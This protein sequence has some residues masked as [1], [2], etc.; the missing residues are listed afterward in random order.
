MV[1]EMKCG[2]GIKGNK[3]IRSGILP[4]AKTTMTIR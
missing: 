4:R 3:K 1:E 2:I